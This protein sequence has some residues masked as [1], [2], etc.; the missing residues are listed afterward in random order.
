MYE[1][2]EDDYKVYEIP[3]EDWDSEAEDAGGGEWVKGKW[4][5]LNK[6][7]ER[8]WEH[9]AQIK[10]E[11]LAKKERQE[12]REKKRKDKEI[13][14]EAARNSKQNNEPFDFLAFQRELQQQQRKEVDPEA[15]I[16]NTD[17]VN[18]FVLTV[19]F[20][21]RAADKLAS[22]RS[23]ISEMKQYVVNTGAWH[24]E[25]QRKAQQAQVHL[26]THSLT[27][28]LTHPPTQLLT[29]LLTHLLT[30][31]LTYLLTYL[32]PLQLSFQG[33]CSKRLNVEKTLILKLKS[34]RFFLRK[35]RLYRE[36]LRVYRLLNTVALS[37]HTP[38]SWAA[39]QGFYGAV[40]E[41]LS[42]GS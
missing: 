7:K 28:L 35:A 12:K 19:L 23:R 27:H 16:G 10:K 31:S 41:L 3:D 42:H 5:P 17:C 29:H 34:T 37:G 22:D 25:Q 24:W 40:E 6:K 33:D 4:I 39:S 15:N 13:R 1:E 14:D 9:H 11:K 2:E 30:Y 21:L 26:L 32:L 18:P 36:K 8:W 38:V 20:L